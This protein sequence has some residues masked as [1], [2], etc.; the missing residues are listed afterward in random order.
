MLE[1]AG[2]AYVTRR[3]DP[4]LVVPIELVDGAPVAKCGKVTDTGSIPTFDGDVACYWWTGTGPSC[5]AYFRN[6]DGT[7]ADGDEF[8]AITPVDR[9]AFSIDG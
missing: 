7:S 6:P 5:V 1:G 4:I 9:W 2:I 8:L 3:S